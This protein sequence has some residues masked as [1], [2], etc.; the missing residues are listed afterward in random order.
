MTVGELLEKSIFCGYLEVTVRENGAGQ[1]IYRYI[2]GE[3]AKIG[4]NDELF[5]KDKWTCFEKCITPDDVYEF[6]SVC[7]GGHYLNGRIIPKKVEKTPKEVLQLEISDWRCMDLWCKKSEWGL[8]VTAYPKGW[9]KPEPI[10]K[11]KDTE[12]MTLF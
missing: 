2:V 7:G 10:Q 8:Y 6:R 11:P 4:K 12:Q 3:E 1:W 9:T 5:I